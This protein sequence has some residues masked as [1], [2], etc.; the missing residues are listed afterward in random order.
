[1]NI[2]LG[3]L[4][5]NDS[6]MRDHKKEI[7]RLTNAIQQ[8]VNLVTKRMDGEARYAKE[9]ARLHKWSVFDSRDSRLNFQVR[10]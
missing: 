3:E 10:K 6:A 9:V 5:R 4:A 1:M 8:L 7:V 2:S